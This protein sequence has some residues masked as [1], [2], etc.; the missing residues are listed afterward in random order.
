[1]GIG[2]T[3]YLKVNKDTANNF[4]FSQGFTKVTACRAGIEK[5]NP[6]GYFHKSFFGFWL[7]Y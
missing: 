3:H 2:D 6:Y 1:M 7:S 4:I 5:K